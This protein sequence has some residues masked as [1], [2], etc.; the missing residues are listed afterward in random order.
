MS[1]GPI[2]PAGSH[3]GFTLGELAVR[4]G[5]VLRGDPGLRVSHV[6]ILQN[7]D[8]GAV[9]FLA[10]P[11]YRKFLSTTRATAVV[12]TAS[13]ALAC[14]SAVL[15]DANPY[16]AYARI[17]TVLYP[18]APL[19]PG[20][21]PSAVI[22][23]RAKLAASAAIGPL[24][25]I[26]DDVHVADRA[27]I[28]P[29]CVLQSGCR[30]GADSKLLGQVNIGAGS[31]VGERCIFHPGAI[32]G[33]DGFGFAP[34]NGAW[35]KVP[36]VGIVRIGDDVEIGASTTIDRGAIGDT[37]IGNGVKLDN[38]IQ[39]GHN[40]NIGDHTIIASC[41]GISGSTI[42]GKRCMIAGM[43]GMAGHLNIADDVVITGFSM[44]SASLPERGAYSSGIPVEPSR[45]WW[46]MVARFRRLT[47]P[48]KQRED[49]A[50]SEDD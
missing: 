15:I 49:S 36:Q 1:E 5:L 23:E 4:F 21:H 33:A 30:I 47:Q 42:I 26:E 19:R 20:V 22:G 12:V 18:L 50:R 25:V 35:A 37:V 34:D 48:N 3:A 45:T 8:L 6:A 39:I 27:Q 16:L 7:A 32:I 28:G 9:S 38:Q 29:G 11:K 46:R 10:N 13:D 14:P 44:V 31:V 17:A 2:I 24:C 43:V 40:V 41:T